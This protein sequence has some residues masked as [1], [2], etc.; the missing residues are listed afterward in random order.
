MSNEIQEVRPMIRT[1]AAVVTAAVAGLLALSACGIKHDAAQPN[2]APAVERP[3]ANSAVPK[4]AVAQ[5]GSLGSVVTDQN[6]RTLYR[7]DMDKAKPPV[8]NCNDDCAVAWPPVLVTDLSEVQLANVD[9][10]LVGTVARQDGGK[11]LTLG[12]WA[13]YRYLADKK[14]GDAKGQGVG[15]TWFAATPDGKKAAAKPAAQ[16]TKPGTTKPAPAPATDPGYGY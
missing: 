8:S 16:P 12:G 3:A 14:A 5:V 10:S 9:K 13:L 7:F 4:L 1:S 15:G 2:T 11:Q 6:G